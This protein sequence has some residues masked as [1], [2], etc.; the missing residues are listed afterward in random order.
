MKKEKVEQIENA[1]KD[2]KCPVLNMAFRDMS[3][4]DVSDRMGTM[5]LSWGKEWHWTYEDAL[6]TLHYQGKLILE[7][8]EHA[9]QIM[10][11]DSV[12]SPINTCHFSLEGSSHWAVNTMNNSKRMRTEAGDDEW[13]HLS[14]VKISSKTWD[15]VGS[16]K[17][18]S[19]SDNDNNAS[20]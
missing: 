8:M 16:R 7:E 11:G 19:F 5:C 3:H 4:V 20:D 18:R 13:E 17:R 9:V 1:L 12:M 14:D 6:I 15:Y 10:E 2:R